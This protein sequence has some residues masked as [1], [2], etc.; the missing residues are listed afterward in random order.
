MSDFPYF[1]NGIGDES[2]KSVPASKALSIIPEDLDAPGRYIASEALAHAVNVALLLGKPLLLTGAP[3]TGKTQ[4]AYA[5]AHEMREGPD[6]PSLAVHKFETKSTSIARD[7][8]YTYDAIAAFRDRE[9]VK[10]A[11]WFLTYQALGRSILEAFPKA[12]VEALLPMPDDREQH[13]GPRRSVVLIDEVDK[14]PRDF[15]NDLLN[16]IDRLYFRVPELGNI[17]SPGADGVG[18]GVPAQ[19]RPILVITSNAEKTLPEP[20]LRRCVFFHIDAPRGSELSRIIETRLPALAESRTKLVADAVQVFE[21]LR[22]GSI[23]SSLSTAEL[24]DWLQVL[25]QFIDHNE[26]LADRPDVIKKTIP[27]LI[28]NERAQQ[29]ALSQITRL[30]GDADR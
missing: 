29:D 10:D 7:L 11:R 8:F 26:T 2:E 24:L 5:I 15:P 1:R 3:G 12:E 27:A 17:G 16:E 28:K 13:K 14:A 30:H 4:L 23:Q 18:A 25:A 20:F 9:G 19:C 22:S 21:E 6:A